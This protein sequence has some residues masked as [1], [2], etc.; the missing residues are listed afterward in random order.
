MTSPLLLPPLLLKGALDDVYDGLKPVEHLG[1][2]RENVAPLEQAIVSVREAVDELEPMI[3]GLRST[4][5]LR[6]IAAR[7]SARTSLS[8]P[9]T[10]RPIGVRTASTTTASGMGSPVD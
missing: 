4:S 5:A 7:S 8:D 6:G 10:A 9:L 2:V 3:P 1:A